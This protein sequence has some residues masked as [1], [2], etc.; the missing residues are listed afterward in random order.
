MFFTTNKIR[1]ISR[2]R[3]LQKKTEKKGKLQQDCY[4]CCCDVVVAVV[5][6]VVVVASKSVT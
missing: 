4:C 5:V 1:N 6:D 3:R 2:W